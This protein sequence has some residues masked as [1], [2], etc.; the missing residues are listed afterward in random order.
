MWYRKTER[1][2]ILRINGALSGETYNDADPYHKDLVNTGQAS[3]RETVR[4][5]MYMALYTRSTVHNHGKSVY[6]HNRYPFVCRTSLIHYT[7]GMPYGVIRQIR[8]P[9]S[10]LNARRNKALFLM[11]V[12]QVIMDEGAVDDENALAHE[13]ARP[14][15][16][17]KKKKGFAF[18]IN[19]G[20]ALAGQ[21]VQM[22]EHDAAYIRQT[23]G[24]TGENRGMDSTAK[25]GIAIQSLQEQGTVITTPIIDNHALAHQIEG[26]IILSL[27]EQFLDKP[28]QFRI[29]GDDIKKHEFVN[30]NDGRPETNINATQADF[31]VAQKDYRQTMRQA[32]SEQALNVAG[33][34]AQA[35]GDPRMAVALIE[36]SVDLQDLPNKDQMTA[37]LR[38]AAGLPPKD[39]TD[40]QREQREA[41]EAQ[42]KKAQA[43]LAQ[44]QA[45]LAIR[46]DTAKAAEMEA[47]AKERTAEAERE[48]ANAVRA[49]VDAV[50]S[51]I[52]AAQLITTNPHLASVADDLSKNL[53]ATLNQS[54]PMSD[55]GIPPMPEQLPPPNPIGE[56]P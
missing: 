12:N 14:D 20:G 21:H 24:V 28:M 39:E 13:V 11:A 23:S 43:D 45:E 18:E 17:I 48:A 52:Q 25:S 54:L 15:G 56:Q 19:A 50:Q 1:V 46:L 10:D 32:L 16:I 27:C 6:A 55:Q 3:I 26:E 29:T 49:K 22:A 35:T 51:M 33:S 41:M 2:K 44:K 34:I 5:Q 37:Q 42:A 4:E 38:A 8:D 47:A 9:Q 40:D 53:D 7:T 31:I 30:V 36:M